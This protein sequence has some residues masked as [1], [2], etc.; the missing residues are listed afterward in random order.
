MSVTAAADRPVPGLS[1][2]LRTLLRF[3]VPLIVLVA[4]VLGTKFVSTSSS[5]ASG[6]K[7]FSA[8]EYGKTEF[9]KVQ[10]AIRKRAVPAATLA[11]G[12]AADQAAAAKKYGV[13]AGTGPE[14]SVSFTGV[15]TTSTSGIYTVKVAGLPAGLLV[16]VQTGPAINGTDLRDAT[17]DIT[18]GQFTNQINYQNAASALNQ[19]M[20]SKVL[21]GVDAAHLSGKTISVVGVFQL[22]NPTG[23]LVTP[24][25]LSVQ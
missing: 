19:Q 5:V 15:A 24:A 7:K 11:Q 2:R 3:G 18:F 22:I 17:G 21:A 14:M 13:D 4:M 9:P 6:P 1:P 8:A 16:R 25:E 23:W 10:A 20:K 12:I